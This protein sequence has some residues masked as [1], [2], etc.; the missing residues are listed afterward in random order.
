MLGLMDLVSIQECLDGYER[1]IRGMDTSSSEELELK[2]DR[3]RI[4]DYLQ[5]KCERE[6]TY[7][8]RK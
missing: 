8:K 5:K 4:I 2:L 6:I 7:E 1:T 3:L